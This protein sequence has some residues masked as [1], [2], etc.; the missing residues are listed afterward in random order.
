MTR[1]PCKI[2]EDKMIEPYVRYDTDGNLIE[3]G[4]YKNGKLHGIIKK[5]AI[6][7]TN[8]G[9]KKRILARVCTYKNG[10]E[11][12]TNYI[13][14][15]DNLTELAYVI[16]R[17]LRNGIP[18]GKDTTIDVKNNNKEIYV[19]Y[20]KPVRIPGSQKMKSIYMH[21]IIISDKYNS[22]NL[23]IKPRSTDSNYT[24]TYITVTNNKTDKVVATIDLD[25][26][27]LELSKLYKQNISST[28]ISLYDSCGEILN[29]IQEMAVHA[30]T[31]N[32]SNNNNKIKIVNGIIYIN[33]NDEYIPVTSKLL[34]R[35]SNIE[36]N[37]PLV[38]LNRHS[39][40]GCIESYEGDSN[41]KLIFING[42]G[43]ILNDQNLYCESGCVTLDTKNK[44]INNNLKYFAIH[45]DT[46]IDIMCNR[47][48]LAYTFGICPS[49]IEGIYIAKANIGKLIAG[50]EE[51]TMPFKKRLNTMHSLFTNILK[52]KYVENVNRLR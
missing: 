52:I 19:A 21:K 12:G 1:P 36:V 50:C 28:C 32:F 11:N 27:L 5:W 7:T 4:T 20:R 2:K 17:N 45:D 10:V 44:I 46:Y 38:K 6:A 34:P 3:K 37:I 39:I 26:E 22:Y 31:Q 8:D 33:I 47:S 9:K 24:I 23:G 29:Y 43:E 48:S 18:S 30:Y 41:E 40:R 42:A 14:E 15:Y 35:L 51:K 16:K 25:K 13:Y 49:D